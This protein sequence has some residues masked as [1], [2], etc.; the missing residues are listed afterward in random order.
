MRTRNFC[1]VFVIAAM[2]FVAQGCSHPERLSAVPADLTTE[3][4]VPGMPQVRYWVDKD[5]EPIVRDGI[6]SFDRQQKHLS[7]IG[8][9]G[10]FPP[11]HYLAV[12][13]GGD[14]GAFGAG[15]LV[16]WSEAG[17]RPEFK[18]VTGVSTGAL[19]APFA[20][21]GPDYDDELKEV[22]TG[23]T[24]E[25]VLEERSIF[26]ALFDDAMADNRPLWNTV[27]RYTN[28]EMLKKIA[29]E[30]EEKG[31]LLLIGTTDL[32]AR[33]AV[34]WNI[35]AIAASGHPNAL[36]LFRNILVASAAIPGVFPPTM[37]DVE[38]N[39]QVYQEMHVDGGAMSQAFVYP[40]SINPRAEALKRGVKIDRTL[41]VIRNDRLD[42]EWA[43]TERQTL[44]IAGRSI[45]SLIHTQGIGD[46][47]KI[48]LIARRDDVDFNLAVIGPD[49]HAKHKEE[50]D[51]EYMNKL[52]DYG[53]QL[54][55]KGY[56]WSKYP[57]GYVESADK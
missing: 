5:P 1:C 33:Q 16:G 23:I 36:E 14:N 20:F 22:Y 29:H 18:L 45:S 4:V 32:D 26:A 42:P 7:R 19:I 44:D 34:V 48:Y 13:G 31:R 37:I 43:S 9:S 21:L 25:D 52:F 49:F 39:G 47:Y 54:A 2:T 8:Y 15:V 30:Y 46:L 24:P 27:S 53:Y 57:P 12:S 10:P 50:F 56:P 40:G 6:A 41:Y 17:T 11:V 38:V 55:R 51:T 3:A 35:G 28:E